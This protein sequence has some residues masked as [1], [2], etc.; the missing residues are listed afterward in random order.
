MPVFIDPSQFNRVAYDLATALDEVRDEA[1]FKAVS[2][3]IMDR[4][5]V[6]DGSRDELVRALP[7]Y[8]RVYGGRWGGDGEVRAQLLKVL[9]P[10]GNAKKKALNLELGRALDQATFHENLDALL[11]LARPPERA[12]PW[13]F[14]DAKQLGALL[15]KLDGALRWKETDALPAQK[16][17]EGLGS[18]DTGIASAAAQNLIKQTLGA[19]VAS[20][21][22]EP[23]V[24]DAWGALER[25]AAAGIIDRETLG[26]AAR[27]NLDRRL[28]AEGRGERAPIE[29]AP[30][31]QHAVQR[32]V[33]TPEQAASITRA[34]EAEKARLAP[35][36]A[37]LPED[38]RR[39]AEQL[40][41][42][43]PGVAALPARS[44]SELGGLME[45][46][47][48][49]RM[50]LEQL[51]PALAAFAREVAGKG[52]AKELL[53][54]A[55]PSELG[56][57]LVRLHLAF[58]RTRDLGLPL[59]ARSAEKV[60]EQ[61][62]KAWMTALAKGDAPVA[63]PGG[64]A[65]VLVRLRRE[66][67]TDLVGP[68][69][70]AIA[71]GCRKGNVECKPL[72]KVILEGG[73]DPTRGPVSQALAT[74]LMN[75]V[76]TAQKE[77]KNWYF[78]HDRYHEHM[79]AMIPRRYWEPLLQELA[80]QKPPQSADGVAVVNALSM[81]DRTNWIEPAAAK[82]FLALGLAAP[83]AG[84]GGAVGAQGL[85]RLRAAFNDGKHTIVESQGS[86]QGFGRDGDSYYTAEQGK[87]WRTDSRTG[88]RASFAELERWRAQAIRVDGDLVI[89]LAD[90][91]GAGWISV[92]DKNTGEKLRRR[93]LPRPIN[94]AA[95]T[96]AAIAPG[97]RV[98]FP[99]SKH[100]KAD[101][102]VS[103]STSFTKDQVD[104]VHQLAP[105]GFKSEVVAVH[106]DHV[107]AAFR[108]H[109]KHQLQIQRFDL[110][111]LGNAKPLFD[112][113]V[114]LSPYR[115]P[116]ALWFAGDRLFVSDREA[117]HVFDLDGDRAKPAGALPLRGVLDAMPRPDG[118]LDLVIALD[119]FEEK[120][121][122]SRII[123]LDAAEVGAIFGAA[124]GAA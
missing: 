105:R 86:L 22:I 25:S 59:D 73:D 68:A 30:A 60:A 36:W 103:L 61:L 43:P 12:E 112:E 15:S 33:A 95:N 116:E 24:L 65:E 35:R 98:L 2:A 7:I 84:G 96:S 55:A 13:V 99:E 113:L 87:I 5:G 122:G 8:W 97:G 66:L 4:H 45:H 75:E 37:E 80:K 27:D 46:T 93:A 64:A 49:G 70:A 91:N 14:E 89:T 16:R 52:Y 34:L 72:A 121:K 106:G 62:T 19:L 94:H 6:P 79:D 90:L 108:N 88:E 26:K 119:A 83:A 71:E 42:A 54:A 18:V 57:E 74:A 3:R 78:P 39:A 63:G 101:F 32:Q 10:D 40:V 118:G 47:G 1:T 29:D 9:A 41:G 53:A 58:A 38:R 109:A 20:D 44:L 115:S 114:V 124:E 117:V 76:I 28:A 104:A 21:R 85:E 100:G 120:A 56:A 48:A 110:P 67:K 11:A 92:H 31:F 69:T 107:Y 123:R 23:S 111:T 81:M 17:P 50:A 77:P 102:V 51:R 82:Y